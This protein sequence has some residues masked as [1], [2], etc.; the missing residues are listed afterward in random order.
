MEIKEKD[1]HKTVFSL[2]PLVFYECNRMAFGLTNA[3]AIFQ[4]LKENNMEEMNLKQCYS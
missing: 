1:K 4:R 2:G 3:S